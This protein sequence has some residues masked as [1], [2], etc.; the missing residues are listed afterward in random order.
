MEAALLLSLYG[1]G[2]LGALR[3]SLLASLAVSL[4]VRVLKRPLASFSRHSEPQRTRNCT[5]RLFVRCG[6]AKHP[7]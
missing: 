7:F 4:V 6:L 2:L 5:P 3:Q 1:V